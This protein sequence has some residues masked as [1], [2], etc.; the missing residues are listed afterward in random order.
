MAKFADVMLPGACRRPTDRLWVVSSPDRRDHM[1]STLSLHCFRYGCHPYR[2]RR[3]LRLHDGPPRI[4]PA[5]HR[6][7]IRRTGGELRQ[8]P[9]RRGVCLVGLYLHVEKQFSGHQIQQ[10]HIKLGRRKREWPSI[11][12]PE[13][14]GSMT[15]VDVLAASAG[16]ARDMAIEDWCRSVWTSFGGNHQTIIALLPNYQISCCSLMGIALCCLCVHS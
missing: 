16:P 15:V 11:H 12:F 14:R 6:G 5:A 10:V 9:D 1:C 8:Q 3:A 7:R 4:Y 13:H 2:I